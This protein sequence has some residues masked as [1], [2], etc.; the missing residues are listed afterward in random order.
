[1]DNTQTPPVIPQGTG[2][3]TG[4]AYDP[5]LAAQG[6][7]QAVQVPTAPLVQSAPQGQAYQELATKKG[8]QSPEDLARAYEALE[9]HN[10]KVEMSLAELSQARATTV[11]EPSLDTKVENQDEAI[12]VVESIVHKAVR[13]LEDRLALQDLIMR[14]PDALSYSAEMARVVRENPGI[15]WE[16]AYKVA[17]FDTQGTQAKQEGAAEAYQTIAKKQEFAVGSS[18]PT[19]KEQ[20]NYDTIQ[21]MIQDKTV[22]FS[23]V[24][25]LMTERFS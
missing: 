21:S 10:K 25:K 22:P 7:G 23:E 1:M 9:S 2:T 19:V 4:A 14:K 5:L 8:F 6:R 15:S 18:S 24:K 13:P 20:M 17:K 11:V 12:K 16:A 3:A